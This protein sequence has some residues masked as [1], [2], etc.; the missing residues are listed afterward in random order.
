MVDKKRY[1][2][3]AEEWYFQSINDPEEYEKEEFVDRINEIRFIVKEFQ[4]LYERSPTIEHL[5]RA[6]VLKETERSKRILSK[7]QSEYEI[8]KKY[9]MRTAISK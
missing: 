6:K 2:S 3:E 8:F 1:L 5:F 7:V 4:K 9:K